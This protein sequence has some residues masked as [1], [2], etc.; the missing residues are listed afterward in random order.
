MVIAVRD[1]RGGELSPFLPEGQ[2]LSPSLG[3]GFSIELQDSEL[4]SSGRGSGRVKGLI[5][6]IFMGGSIEL[7]ELSEMSGGFI[8]I[9]VMI[10]LRVIIHPQ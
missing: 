4:Q 10:I 8:I 9:G 6:I 2:D 5:R 7:S 3:V 1:V